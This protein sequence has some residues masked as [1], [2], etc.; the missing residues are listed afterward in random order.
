MKTRFL[1]LLAV[2]L[3][4][5]FAAGC[6]S[7]VDGR[8]R[9][10]MPLSK[11]EIENRYERPVSQ[12]FAVA[13]DVLGRNG[14]LTSE[15][16]ISQTLEAKIDRNTVWVKVDEVESQVSRVVV[17][18]RKRGGGGNVDLASEIATQIGIGLAT[19]R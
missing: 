12:V 19:V 9:A 14:T 10:G 13:R 2:G 1:A 4:T 8:M 6:Y 16:T 7:S 15:N 18:A 17:Q 11:D 5:L 3:T